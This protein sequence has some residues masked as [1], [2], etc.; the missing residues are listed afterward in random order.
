M[1]LVDAQREWPSA[2]AVCLCTV[3]NIGG[4]HFRLIAKVYYS[5]QVILVRA[6][7]MHSEYDKEGWK[8]DCGC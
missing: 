2:E 4:N 6:I 3:F 5:D 8:N 7:L 1:N